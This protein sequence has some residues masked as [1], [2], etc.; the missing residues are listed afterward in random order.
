M[1]ITVDI[2]DAYFEEAMRRSWCVE[3]ADR[4]FVLL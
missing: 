1:K 2:L 3:S 4:E